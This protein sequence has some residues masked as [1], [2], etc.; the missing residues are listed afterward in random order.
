MKK[1][2]TL[3]WIIVLLLLC[4]PLMAP[5]SGWRAGKVAPPPVT[6]NPQ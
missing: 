3:L 5:Q 2:R 4:I 6:T 1:I